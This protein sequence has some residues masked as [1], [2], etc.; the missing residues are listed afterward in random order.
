MK[1]ITAAVLLALAAGAAQAAFFTGN[2][3]YGNC[4][5]GSASDRLVCTAY[6][7]GA[8]DM[9][10]GAAF[11]APDAL[12]GKQAEDLIVRYLRDNPQ[13]RHLGADV[14]IYALFKATWPCPEN[15][16]RPQRSPI[17]VHS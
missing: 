5:S 16:G 13:S 6:V 2:T 7:L 4:T 15:S 14:L 1:R 8:V 11:C 10:Q 9:G 17:G 3:L 12:T